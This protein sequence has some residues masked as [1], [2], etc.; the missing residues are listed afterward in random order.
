MRRPGEQRGQLG[1]HGPLRGQPALR[2][3]QRP[4]PA[5]PLPDR[6]LLP[7][8]I[9][10]QLGQHL[11]EVLARV[12]REHVPHLGEPQ[13]QLGEPPDP[14]Q[15]NG[16]PQRVLPVPVG[17]PLRLGQQPQMVVVPHGPRGDTDGRGEFS[18]PH[19]TSQDVD[20]AAGSSTHDRTKRGALAARADLD[21]AELL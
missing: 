12:V 17:P 14:R 15:Q 8:Q 9:L 18:D 16:V 21:T 20:A 2:L 19:A 7:R 10:V 1:R 5:P 4:Q 13:P 11:D 3:Q 6:L